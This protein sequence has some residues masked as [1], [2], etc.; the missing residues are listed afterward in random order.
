MS[1]SGA[2]MLKGLVKGSVARSIRL[3]CLYAYRYGHKAGMGM[4]A[5]GILIPEP[6][7]ITL[8]IN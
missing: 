2:G 4:S 1:K 7:P 5:C 3:E 8:P 6:T